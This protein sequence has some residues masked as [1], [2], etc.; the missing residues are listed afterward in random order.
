MELAAFIRD[1]VEEIARGVRLANAA[2]RKELK[3]GQ[4]NYVTIP[5]GEPGQKA[6]WI[7]FDIAVQPGA[8]RGVEVLRAE[9]DAGKAAAAAAVSR[10][11]FTVKV[12]FVFA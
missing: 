3:G 6:G 7:D 2:V 11:G 5:T 9:S 12:G 10:L 1:S 4:L 8:K